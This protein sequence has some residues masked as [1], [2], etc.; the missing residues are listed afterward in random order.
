MSKLRK[1]LLEQK[2]EK[3][4]EKI[5]K[6]HL[7]QFDRMNFKDD[8]DFESYLNDLEQELSDDGLKNFQGKPASGSV[9]NYQDEAEKEFISSL[10]KDMMPR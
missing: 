10:V 8:E 2:L 7:S 4:P 5:K 6:M 3:A 9:L 1:Q